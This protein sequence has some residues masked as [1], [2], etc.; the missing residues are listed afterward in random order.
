MTYK[1]NITHSFDVTRLND[2]DTFG[3]INFYSTTD[4]QRNKA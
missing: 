3:Q 1:N 4:K 2:D